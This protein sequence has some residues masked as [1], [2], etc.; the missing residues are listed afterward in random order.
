VWSRHVGGSPRLVERTYCTLN[1]QNWCDQSL[2]TLRSLLWCAVILTTGPRD[3]EQKKQDDMHILEMGAQHNVKDLI[4]SESPLFAGL[5]W[6]FHRW[7]K[8]YPL[9]EPKLMWAV[10]K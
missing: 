6:M 9:A 4:I 1:W 5:H 2:Y 10:Q 3:S 8:H 7:Q